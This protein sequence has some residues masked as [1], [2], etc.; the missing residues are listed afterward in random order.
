M[1]IYDISI[2]NFRGIVDL[3]NLKVGDINSFVGKNDSGKSNI[4]KA[5]N[6]F[7]NEKFDSNDVY[8]GIQ[9][10]Q[11]TEITIRFIPKS[12]VNPLALDSESK[13]HLKK[14]FE[15]SSAG[16]VVKSLTYICNDIDSSEYSNCWGIKESS[17][18]DFCN[19]L[20]VEFSR[21]GRGVTNLSKIDLINENTLGLGRTEKEYDATEF[22]KNIKKQYTFVELPVFSLFD[23]E[24][25]LNISATSF[26][27][28]FKPIATESLKNNSALTE[29]IETNVQADL[30]SEFSA[31]TTLMQKNVPELEKIKTSPVCNWNNLVK[32]DLSLKFK[33]DNYDIP[34]SNKGT[35]FKRLLMVA[36]F[37]YLAQK[38]TK[39]HHIFGIEEPETFLHPELQQ[40]LLS[41]IV[42]LADN[43]QFF[44]TTHSPVFAGSTKDSNIVVV[45]KEEEVSKY[46]NYENDQEILDVV[47]QELGIKPNY[48]LLNDNYRKAIFVEGSGDVKFWE[49]VL[50][51]ITGG[52]PED[53]LF[54][55]CGGDQ[56]DFFVNA[57][58]CQK[59]NRRFIV[60]LDSDKGAVDYDSKLANKSQLIGK[61]EGLGGKVMILR[62]REIENYY[63]R[64]AIQRVLGDAFQ[65]PDEFQIDDFSDIKEEIK[66]HILT[67]TG[68]NFKAKNNLSIF[69]EMTKE[70]WISS[71]VTISNTTDLQEIINKIK[72]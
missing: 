21:S 58:L 53:I 15:F 11:K 57:H 69:N 60:V 13:V 20:G 24:Q 6:T 55:P 23:A 28:Q 47:I 10:G 18:N 32:F 26:Q 1:K 35:G 5:L 33:T 3:Q 27:S 56:V 70:E 40:D 65:L 31:I 8:K 36:Y 17:I 42:E 67:P 30:E 16:K 61:V 34:I 59:I 7:F 71:A 45:K 39:Q 64:D 22:L 48:N 54:V 19:S 41:S 52:I 68:M 62:K 14:T 25:D 29:Q 4:L 72:E 12:E 66:T 46:Y 43:S 38:N 50:S 44:L 37:E 9:E 51:K 2:K 49:I 63:S